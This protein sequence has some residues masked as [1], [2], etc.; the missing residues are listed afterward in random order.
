[1]VTLRL[2]QGQDS[3]KNKQIYD[4]NNVFVDTNLFIILHTSYYRILN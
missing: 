3:C 4:F 2:T 1:M